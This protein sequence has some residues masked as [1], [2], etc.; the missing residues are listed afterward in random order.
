MTRAC[1]PEKLIF[2]QKPEG[3]A[4]GHR[5][6][7]CD[8]ARGLGTIAHFN[9]CI[10]RILGAAHSFLMYLHM[11][12]VRSR[13]LTRSGRIKNQLFDRNRLCSHFKV[14]VAQSCPTLCNSMDCMV[15]GILQARILEWVA[16]PF[17][18]GSSQPRD[19]IQVSHNAGRFFTS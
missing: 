6:L 13:S 5:M 16:F 8:R 1:I 17:S 11:V 18:R 2:E 15:H 7:S 4:P 12:L 19:R 9:R 14:Q 3:G 10:G